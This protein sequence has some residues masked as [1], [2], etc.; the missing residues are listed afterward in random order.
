MDSVKS[1][2]FCVHAR[3]FHWSHFLCFIFLGLRTVCGSLSTSNTVAWSESMPV[4]PSF[5]I[6]YKSLCFILDKPLV[7]LVVHSLK[8]TGMYVIAIVL[9]AYVHGLN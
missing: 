6:L 1:T 5:C 3:N 4:G 9:K 2:R 7:K 8:V